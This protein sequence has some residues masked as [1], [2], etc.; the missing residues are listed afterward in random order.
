MARLGRAE[1]KLAQ[2]EFEVIDLQ[3]REAGAKWLQ[4]VQRHHIAVL[5]ATLSTKR[6]PIRLL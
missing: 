6:K 3:E 2:R 1:T 5:F 4:D